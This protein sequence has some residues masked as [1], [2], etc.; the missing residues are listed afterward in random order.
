VPTLGAD[1]SSRP[2]FGG[3]AARAFEGSPLF[4]RDGRRAPPASVGGPA[5]RRRP[6]V[7]VQSRFGGSG[8]Q[9]SLRWRVGPGISVLGAS[10]RASV[11]E[12][13][14]ASAGGALPLRRWHTATDENDAVVWSVPS[15]RPSGG[16]EGPWPLLREGRR[17][18]KAPLLRVWSWRQPGRRSAFGC[19]DQGQRSHHLL[20]GGVG[21]S[22]DR[23]PSGAR[24]RATRW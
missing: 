2:H 8:R 17:C 6:A 11:R 5:L 1:P 16:S 19:P 13:P 15:G 12:T 3:R 4:L 9:A 21:G 23:I 24:D 7:N 18:Q 10:T 22:P 14:R 20:A